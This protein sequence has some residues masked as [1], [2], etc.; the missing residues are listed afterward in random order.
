VYSGKEFLILD[1]SFS[2]LD[3]STEDAMFDNLLGKK[4]ILRQ[5]GR[6]MLLAS[7]NSE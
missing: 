5:G 1:D 4:G 3:P 2:G 7:S 6:T